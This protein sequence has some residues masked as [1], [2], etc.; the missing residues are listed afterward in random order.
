MLVLCLLL[1]FI[2]R[3]ERGRLL[4]QLVYRDPHTRQSYN[5]I[6]DHSAGDLLELAEA[7]IRL[8]ALNVRRV[9][10]LFTFFFCHLFHFTGQAINGAE[11]DLRLLSAAENKLAFKAE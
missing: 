9:V 1:V 3:R 6:F 10:C 11:K 5:A 2:V 7:V 4:V 8:F